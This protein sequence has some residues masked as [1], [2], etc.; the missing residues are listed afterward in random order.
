MNYFVKKKVKEQSGNQ[1]S[2]KNQSR[3]KIATLMRADT[4]NQL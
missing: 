1:I 4:S 3:V 2:I